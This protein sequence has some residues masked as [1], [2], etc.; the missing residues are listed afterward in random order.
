MKGKILKAYKKEH[1]HSYASGAYATMELL[2]G[3]SGAVMAVYV[4][5]KYTGKE[6]MERLC[7][8]RDI[9]VVY[10]DR[11]FERINRKENSYV[12]GVFRKYICCLMPE[13]PHVVLVNPNDMGNLGTIIRTM[14]GMNMLDLAVVTPAADIFHPK[15]VRASM[16]ALFHIRFQCFPTFAAY[17]EEFS[18]HVCYPFTPEGEI[19]LNRD[20]C[21]QTQLFSLLFGNEASGLPEHCKLS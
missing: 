21:P 6:D 2:E 13:C 12:L 16:G 19:L 10:D 9:P 20:N 4:H 18:E 14:V 3:N 17:Q 1:A 11:A 15:T 5:S 8:D 7:R